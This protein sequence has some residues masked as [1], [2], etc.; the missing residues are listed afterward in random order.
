MTFWDNIEQIANPAGILTIWAFPIVIGIP[1][2]GYL[3]ETIALFFVILF[4][5]RKRYLFLT[6]SI[7][8]SMITL[9]LVYGADILVISMWAKA[10]LPGALL[11]Y[12]IASGMAVSRV[13]LV[14][15]LSITGIVLILFL[16]EKTAI[17]QALDKA[18]VW[19]EN[20]LAGTPNQ[21]I[22]MIEVMRK[23]VTVIKRLMPAIMILSVITQLFVGWVLLVIF[24]KAIG[25][26]F[27]GFVNFY[28]WKM[29]DF[30][31]PVIGIVMIT[32]L[33]G[34]D[35]LKVVAD[36]LILFIGF[37]YAAFGFALFEYYLKKIKLSLF[38]RVLFYI[39]FI[40]LQLPGLILAAV[41][42]LFD[43]Y[44]DFR[45]VKARMIG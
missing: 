33:L 22:E 45:N 21:G 16:Q 27:P 43:S 34:G 35:L 18:L 28:Y 39:G 3:M 5:F 41:V 38:L 2:M 20:G 25:E 29:P 19:I 24:L 13:F 12:L 4:S 6:V 11:G 7:L 23:T 17:F 26:F 30:Y 31:L 44:F 14:S 10:I 1:A 15:I 37:F 8:G 9:I 42:G 36:N 32:R 40:F